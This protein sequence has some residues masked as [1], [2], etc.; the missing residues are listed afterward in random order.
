MSRLARKFADDL[1]ERERELI[2]AHDVLACLIKAGDALA[3][4]IERYRSVISCP[5]ANEAV[6]K[7][8]AAKGTSK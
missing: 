5:E 2:E 1:V 8:D 6:T 4:I 3:E 7:W